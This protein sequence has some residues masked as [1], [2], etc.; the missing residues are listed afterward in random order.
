M[1]LLYDF[2][3]GLCKDQKSRDTLVAVSDMPQDICHRILNEFSTRVLSMKIHPV[4][5]D[6]IVMGSNRNYMDYVKRNHTF[7]GAAKNEYTLTMLKR[8]YERVNTLDQGVKFSD[9]IE[10]HFKFPPS[11][12]FMNSLI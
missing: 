11:R 8:T 7:M 6:D 12:S 9:M 1:S 2:C 4:P 10:S 3:L 5:E